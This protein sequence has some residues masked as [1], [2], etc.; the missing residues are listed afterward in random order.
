MLESPRCNKVA[1]CLKINQKSHENI[2]GEV[3]PGGYLS[4]PN[5]KG[6]SQS[7][8]GLFQVNNDGRDLYFEGFH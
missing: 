7:V 5:N 8:Y 1:L 3:F 6:N 2:Y 4:T